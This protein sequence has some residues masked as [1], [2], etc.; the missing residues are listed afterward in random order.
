MVLLVL[1]MSSVDNMAGLERLSGLRRR[2]L[3]CKRRWIGASSSL[4]AAAAGAAAVR[5]TQ[6]MMLRGEKPLHL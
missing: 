6:L 1:L 4:A 3:F 5:A 2:R